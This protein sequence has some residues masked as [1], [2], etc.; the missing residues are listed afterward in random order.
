MVLAKDPL[1]S[2][3]FYIKAQTFDHR[4]M[5]TSNF[6]MSQSLHVNCGVSVY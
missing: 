5:A 2:S 4:L 3:A 6:V 1:Y